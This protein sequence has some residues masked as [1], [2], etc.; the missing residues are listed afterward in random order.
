MG[1]KQESMTVDEY[2]KRSQEITVIGSLEAIEDRSRVKPT[3]VSS[4]ADACCEKSITLSKDAIQEVRTIG[5]ARVVEVVLK[6]KATFTCAVP[7]L[8]HGR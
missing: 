2:L 4:S 5:A 8:A 6:G 3:L 7:K 1:E